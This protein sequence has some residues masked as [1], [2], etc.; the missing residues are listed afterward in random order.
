MLE[1][2]HQPALPNETVMND[3]EQS[4]FSD[5]AVS[6]GANRPGHISWERWK[7]PIWILLWLVGI[8]AGMLG[9]FSMLFW[10]YGVD[11]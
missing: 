10:A 9:F 4:E 2:L 6:G 1:A 3:I 7:T 5:Y 11:G 8:P